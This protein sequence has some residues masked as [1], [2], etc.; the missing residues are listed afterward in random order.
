MSVQTDFIALVSAIFAGRVYPKGSEDSPL[1]PYATFF[2]VVAVEEPT[3]DENGGTGNPINTRL[4]V[5]VYALSYL[6]AQAKASAV[7]AALKG[8]SVE[9]ILLGDQDGHEPE[10]KLHSVMLDIST[11][12]L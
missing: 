4:Q 2:R 6:D 9:N 1:P 3:L 8:W 11:W 10:T 5:D 7:K 12:H